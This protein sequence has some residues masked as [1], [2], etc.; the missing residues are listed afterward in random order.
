MSSP[1]VPNSFMYGD[2]PWGGQLAPMIVQ[3]RIPT[4]TDV[5]PQGYLWLADQTLGGSGALYYQSGFLSG[6]PSW[7]LLATSGAGVFTSVTSSG[8]IS[9]T[10]GNIVANA[11]SITAGTNLVAG[12]TV[13][14]ATGVIATT[15]N[16]TAT[17]G[18]LA[19]GTA[20]N[21][22]V[23]ATGANASIGT[24]AAMTAGSIVVATTAVT[25][26]SIIFV[27]HN[28]IAGTAGAV[29]APAASRVAGTSFTITSSSNTDTSTVNWWIVN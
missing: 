9:S 10:A 15:G 18:N 4:S 24:S 3:G 2:L 8:N 11:G 1:F 5:A 26:S 29:S 12:T 16:L 13:T 27:S 6:A 25:A 19:L 21:K 23:I 22:V 14:G 20:G 7:I 28:T 17:N